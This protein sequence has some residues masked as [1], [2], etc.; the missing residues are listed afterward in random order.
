MLSILLPLL[1]AAA[2]GFGG[3]PSD[4]GIHFV[5]DLRARRGSSPR[6]GETRNRMASAP[7]ADLAA[8]SSWT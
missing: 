4:A 3:T 7:V 6:F 8:G 2:D 1:E 5:E